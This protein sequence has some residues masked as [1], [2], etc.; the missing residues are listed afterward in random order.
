MKQ[1][2]KHDFNARH[3]IYDVYNCLLKDNSCSL[4]KLRDN[5]TT[6]SAA[7]D[8]S[9][10]FDMLVSMRHDSVPRDISSIKLI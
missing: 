5:C 2:K 3:G 1:T 8:N 10:D 6:A 9:N 7:K 4:T